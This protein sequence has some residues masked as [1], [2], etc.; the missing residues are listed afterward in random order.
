[1]DEQLEQKIEEMKECV[2]SLP[3]AKFES[4]FDYIS[5]LTEN[6]SVLISVHKYN[7]KDQPAL[8]SKN[9]NGGF[10]LD[11][12]SI[13]SDMSESYEIDLQINE[14]TYRIEDL[15]ITMRGTTLTKNTHNEFFSGRLVF[16][17]K[18]H[19]LELKNGK[20]EKAFNR[21]IIPIGSS[22]LNYYVK[23]SIYKDESEIHSFGR[24]VIKIEDEEFT[25]Y[26]KSK[27]GKYYFIIDSKNKIEF[28]KFA[29]ICYSIMVGFGFL[30]ANL[31][32]NE[33]YY[34]KSDNAEF[35]T[36][37][38]F[39][40][41][42]LRPSID[43][44][45]TCNPIYSNPYGYTKDKTIINIVGKQLNVFDD[46]LFSDLC[47]KIYKQE[48]YTILILLILEANASSLI[49][50]PAGYAVAL[51]KIT[52]IIVEENKG[53]KPIPDKGLS[54]KF[55]QSLLDV[56]EHYNDDINNVGNED[57]V[58]ILRKNIDKINNPT[59]RDKLLKPFEILKINI[60]KEDEEAID[61]RNKF[62]H[63]RKIQ[64]DENTEDYIKI[65]EITLR[66]NNLLNKLILKHIGFSGYVINHLK[67]NEKS[68]KSPITSDLFEKI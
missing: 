50:R 45:G 42:Q 22:Q 46:K 67:H 3:K 4:S 52:N 47:A 62:L 18:I 1:M 43:S 7:I 54:K 55:R 15:F 38:D 63:G 19:K 59:N 58:T 61:N 27:K 65:F 51:E 20:K 13:V 26:E 33:A 6:Q 14:K 36:I 28:E 10:V 41:S 37:T 11:I 66:L 39:S 53:L 30:S 8:L 12:E 68:F 60:S 2:D 23:A 56:L 44:Q 5:N 57:S 34:F 64:T 17:G 16:T 9:E 29:D 21:F 24:V 48:D 49:L 25:I 40:Y 35:D 31:I 32:Q